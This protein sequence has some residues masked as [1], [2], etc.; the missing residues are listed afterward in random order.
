MEAGLPGVKP[1]WTRARAVEDRDRPYQLVQLA[2]RMEALV[3]IAWWPAEVL[4]DGLADCYSHYRGGLHLPG[5]RPSAP[6]M[7]LL[8]RVAQ[9][10]QL[11][12]APPPCPCLHPGTEK[13][14]SWPPGH[15]PWRAKVSVTKSLTFLSWGLGRFSPCQDLSACKWAELWVFKPCLSRKHW[16]RQDPQERCPLSA[17]L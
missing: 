10:L 2:V 13:A 8:P 11:C 15:S 16:V 14:G 4:S 17:P 5:S 9:Y 3:L 7:P 6:R 12:A 1:S